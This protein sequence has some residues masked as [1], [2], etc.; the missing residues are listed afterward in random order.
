MQ[1]PTDDLPFGATVFWLHRP[2]L[3]EH[4]W[5]MLVVGIEDIR[6]HRQGGSIA[7]FDEVGQAA[8]WLREAGYATLDDLKADGEVSSA[9]SPPDLWSNTAG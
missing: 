2:T 5:A 3:P 8:E 1:D 7:L 9:L 6:V 4:D